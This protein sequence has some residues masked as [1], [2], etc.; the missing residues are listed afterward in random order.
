MP[1][2]TSSVAV[3]QDTAGTHVLAAAE[4]LDA[5]LLVGQV[6]DVGALGAEA[7][8]EH[9]ERVGGLMQAGSGRA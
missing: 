6:L 4:D 1:D 9:E 8:V 5:L 3:G 2:L 7:V